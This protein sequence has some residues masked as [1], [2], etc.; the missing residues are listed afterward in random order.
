MPYTRKTRDTWRLLAW[1]DRVYGWEV[2][3]TEYSPDAIRARVIEHQ[4]KHPKIPVRVI[5]R[6]EPIEPKADGQKTGE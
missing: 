3:A 6:R 5:K 2:Q 1:F 4:Q